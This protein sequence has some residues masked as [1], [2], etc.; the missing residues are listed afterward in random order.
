MTMD[1]QMLAINVLHE[2]RLAERVLLEALDAHLIVFQ[3]HGGESTPS[4]LLDWLKQWAA[5]QRIPDAAVEFF[6]DG[7]TPE[8]TRPVCSELSL[9]IRKHE[10]NLIIDRGPVAEN[11]I[12]IP[13]RFSPEQALALSL[14]QASV[15]QLTTHNSYRGMGINE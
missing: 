3:A 12:V 14:A 2:T 7:N 15:G 6:G 1:S 4:F 5:Q 11:S 10:L 8:P 13:V 9:F